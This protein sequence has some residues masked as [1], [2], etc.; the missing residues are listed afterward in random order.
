MTELLLK[1]FVK[2]Y[3]H[4]EDPKVRKRYGLLGTYFGLITNLLLFFAK[5]VI[6][7]LLRLYSIVADSVNN[8]SDFGNNLLSLIGI[9]VSAK[10]A[11]REHP[12]GHQRIEYIMSLIIACVIISLAVVMFYQGVRDTIAFFTTLVNTHQPPKAEMS[13]VMYV[14]SLSILTA[15]ILFKLLQANLYLSL[16]KRIQSMQLKALGKDAVN[17]VFSTSCVILG[18]LIA[19]FTGY[20]VD[21]FFTLFVSVLVTLSGVQI[22][23]E[24]INVLIGQEP[25]KELVDKIINLVNSHKDALGMHDLSLHYYGNVI[26]GVIHIEVD[27]SKDIFESHELCDTIEK[28]ALEKLNINLTVHMDP[29]RVNDYETEMYRTLIQQGLKDYPVKNITMHDFRLVNGPSQVNIVFDLVIPQEINNNDD[30]KQL[31]DFLNR[32]TDNK[33]GKRSHLD[34]HFDSELTDF[35]YGTSAEKNNR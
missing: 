9:K 14:T 5:I 35:L 2:D 33:N 23:K 31:T 4:V 3:R 34:I 29:I 32:Y 18:I 1:L 10:P 30:R 25:D 21:C 19:W 6:G 24:A 26:Y 15:A 17:D 13:Y 27:A 22:M 12:Y 28:E 16:G 8:L 20:D 11:D 7:L